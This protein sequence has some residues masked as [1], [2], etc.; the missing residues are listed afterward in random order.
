MRHLSMGGKDGVGRNCAH[1]S[2]KPGLISSKKEARLDGWTIWA[3]LGRRRAE[4]VETGRSPQWAPPAAK[5]QRSECFS[6]LSKKS[7][8]KTNPYHPIRH[9]LFP[10]KEEK[11][12]SHPMMMMGWGRTTYRM[13][14]T[15]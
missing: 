8:K 12:T 15:T 3:S 1:A 9:V 10:N 14:T 5:E 2:S 6:F 13:T 4:F 7:V 11:N